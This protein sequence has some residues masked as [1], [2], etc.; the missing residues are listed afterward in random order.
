MRDKIGII[1][2][3]L[4]YGFTF[5]FLYQIVIGIATSLLSLPLT[6]NIQDLISGVE[7]ID[8]QHGPWL[9]IWWITST[10]II[11][12]MALMIIRYKKYISPYKEEKNIEVPPQ[13]TAV[14]AII[15]GALISFLFFLL[16]SVI[17][18]VVEAG[19]KTDVEAIY[20]AAIVGDFTPLVISIVF[21]I[22]AGFIIVGVASKTS[23]VKE[24]T[25]DIGLQD[26]TKISQIINKTKT[27]KTSL[28]DTI[29]QSPGAL[30][31]V[32]EQK[33][34][35]VRIDMLE[36]DDK[37]IDEKTDV[38]IEDCIESK[39]KPNVTW[40]NVIGIHDP[41]IIE[42][43]GNSFEIHPL[44]QS[45]IMNTELRPS[46]EVSDKY[47]LILLKMPHFVKETQKLELE[48]IS[49]VLA[50]HHVITF[51]EI[52]ADFFDQIRN[53]LRSNTGTIRNQKSDYLTYAIVD[54]IV[55]SYFLVIERIGDITEEL[56]EELMQNPTADT[57][58]TIQ[59][60]KRRMIALR[61]S[62]WP[63][64]EI[65]DFLGRDSTMLISDNTRTYLRD[66]YNHT[67]QV[68]DTI[69]GL[70]DVIGG[71]LDTYLS[72][73][74]NRMNEVMKTLTIIAAIFI[75]ITFIAGLYGTNFVYVPELQWEYSYFAML[76]VM[77]VI[78][79]LMIIWFKKKKWL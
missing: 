42:T 13:I 43:F 38:K 10:I 41:H 79:T 8:S 72:S 34:E 26:L 28:S 78:T 3:R 62:I 77:A 4:V 58:Q 36:Y 19:T 74:S 75:P 47:V 49:I 32:G 1:I 9:V 27:Q 50:K 61:K 57:M 25:K 64:R 29:G 17:G 18:L 76:S 24:I 33:V 68:I 51:Q 69:E 11:T 67:V 7:Q 6:G 54:A 15:I 53:R 60:L 23:K 21:S 46:I 70:R 16:D 44:H 45:N 55:D 48:Q 22:M 14:T 71:M 12:V 30:I 56:E 63:A 59:T 37:T 73:V 31:H 40:I 66:V 5:A 20:Q 52:E 2:N 65:I 35:N 39:D